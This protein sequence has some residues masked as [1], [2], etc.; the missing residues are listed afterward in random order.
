MLENMM[1]VS[2]RSVEPFDPNTELNLVALVCLR[3]FT[4]NG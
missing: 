2:L 1:N 3:V 4:A